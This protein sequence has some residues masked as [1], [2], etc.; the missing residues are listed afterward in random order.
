MSTSDLKSIRFRDYCFRKPVEMD[1]SGFPTKIKIILAFGAIY[2]IWGSTYLA[3]R[4][5]IETIPPF[6]M[7]GCR[8]LLAGGI[9]YAWAR[10]RGDDR[11]KPAQWVTAAIVGTLLFL[12]GHGALAWSEQIIP[13]GVAALIVATTP[14]WMTLLE[15]FRYHDN[16]LTGRVIIGLVAGFFGVALLAEP[17]KIFGGAPVDPIG[18][19]VLLLGTL[20]WCFGVVYMKNANLPKSSILGAGMNLLT[21]GG[22]LLLVSYL[23][24][25]TMALTSVSLRSLASLLY[26]IAFGSIITFTAYI[27]LLKIKSPT[28]VSTHAFVNPLVAVFVGRFAG[29]E[30]LS[31]R[32]LTAA[33]LMVTGVAA[34]VTRTSASFSSART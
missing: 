2:L 31:P 11:P 10:L 22:G 24:R 30:L 17:A 12:V 8:S 1:A 21:G 6:F 14:I 20:S 9:L 15:A 23:S 25:E 19:L 28:Q 32:I 18:A 16:P 13:S 34:I 33:L 4:F 3:I 26:L 7:M 27:W 29:G 5:A